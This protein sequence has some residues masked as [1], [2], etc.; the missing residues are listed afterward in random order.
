[1][2]HNGKEI[3][4]KIRE[5][6]ITWILERFDC[7]LFFYFFGKSVRDLKREGAAERRIKGVHI[8]SSTP[9]IPQRGYFEISQHQSRISLGSRA[10]HKG[11]S[12]SVSAGS[13]LA[14]PEGRQAR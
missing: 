4:V 5:I 12:H 3:L 14:L 9:H 10:E 6:G 8:L 2:L 11:A 1:M 7:L 13:W